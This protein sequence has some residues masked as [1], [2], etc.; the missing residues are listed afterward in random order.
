MRVL[1]VRRT[2]QG[3]HNLKRLSPEIGEVKEQVKII[4]SEK[5]TWKTK[6]IK[7]RPPLDSLIK[8]ASQ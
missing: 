2:A 4:Y 5:I 6:H 7:V 3:K 8:S 1:A